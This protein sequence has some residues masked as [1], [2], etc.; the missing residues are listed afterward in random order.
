ML[1]GLAFAA[2]MMSFTLASGS[3]FDVREP[4]ENRD[5]NKLRQRVIGRGPVQTGI[6]NNIAEPASEQRVAIRC[7]SDRCLCSDNGARA[8]AVFDKDALPE[9]RTQLIGRNPRHHVIAPAGARRHDDANRPH[10]IIVGMRRRTCSSER[11]YDSESS[12]KNF[13]RLRRSLTRH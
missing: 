13:H 7:R 6:E 10:W 12:C 4:V 11:Q 3:V 2:A 9:P 5:R 8:G 1:P